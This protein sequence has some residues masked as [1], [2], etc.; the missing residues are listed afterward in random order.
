M[1]F[2]QNLMDGL[3]TGLCDWTRS[4][5]AF[6]VARN[7]GAE[8]ALRAHLLPFLE[9]A[10]NCLA[11]TESDGKR[12]DIS[13]R[14]VRTPEEK[15]AFLELKHN[16]LLQQRGPVGKE[17]EK[18]IEKLQ[19]L[20]G[21]GAAMIGRYYLHAVV[22]LSLIGQGG[23]IVTAHNTTVGN[24]SYKRFVSSEA[25]QCALVG[26]E[27]I[28]TCPPAS[29]RVESPADAQA[30]ATLHCWLFSVPELGANLRE[31]RLPGSRK[32]YR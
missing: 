14:P 30:T 22:E 24:A 15:I 29:Y 27:E 13:L 16:L 9:D 1:S 17:R 32:S 26:V 3:H 5:G 18:A 2:E 10:T 8:F 19:G 20:T 25:L 7:G 31:M 23:D 28:M 11:F 4:K 6:A 21:P 12:I